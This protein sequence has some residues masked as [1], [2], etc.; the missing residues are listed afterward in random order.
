MRR[1]VHGMGVAGY[2]GPPVNT[3]SPVRAGM[4]LLVYFK[5]KWL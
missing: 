4:P 3:G 5:K 2:A 1:K